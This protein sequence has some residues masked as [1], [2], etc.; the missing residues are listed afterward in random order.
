MQ[1]LQAHSQHPIKHNGHYCTCSGSLGNT[2]VYGNSD[3][4]VSLLI[5][6]FHYC[7]TV[8][9]VNYGLGAKMG[10]VSV[11]GGSWN[12]SIVHCSPFNGS[13]K[14]ISI[15]VRILKRVRTSTV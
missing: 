10:L 15:W 4:I 5:L 13:L 2:S 8:F 3:T 6:L 12:E 14:G 7:R 1:N 11:S 9:T